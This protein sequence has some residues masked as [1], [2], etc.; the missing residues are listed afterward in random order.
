MRPL[1]PAS[2]QSSK[3]TAPLSVQ[4][5]QLQHS[6]ITLGYWPS[7][8][9]RMICADLLHHFRRRCWRPDHCNKGLVTATLNRVEFYMALRVI[10]F[11]LF[12]PPFRPFLF[13]EEDKIS[14][15]VLPRFV[16]TP[17]DSRRRLPTIL[18]PHLTGGQESVIESP[19]CQFHWSLHA[20]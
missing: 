11:N 13:N 5:F 8:H 3:Y 1:F 18:I 17:D 6:F 9:C 4:M 2:Q 20:L 14:N 7:P 16:Q 19:H 12:F 15:P 10:P